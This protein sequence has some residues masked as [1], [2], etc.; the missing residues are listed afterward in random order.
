MTQGGKADRA[1][2]NLTHQSRAEAAIHFISNIFIYIYQHGISA[3][4][5]P[6]SKGPTYKADEC[7]LMQCVENYATPYNCFQFSECH[8]KDHFNSNILM[9]V[10]GM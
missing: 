9:H 10:H 6:F 8:A 2:G 4:I 1:R 7:M 5:L 3:L